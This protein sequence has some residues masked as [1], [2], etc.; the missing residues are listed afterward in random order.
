MWKLKAWEKMPEYMQTEEVRRYYNILKRKKISLCFKRIFDI[1]MSA[2]LLIILS[3]VLLVLSVWIKLDSKGPIFFRQVRITQYGEMF[4]IFKFRTMVNDAER[5]G[6]QV[7]VS[8]DSR[9][10]KVGKLIRKTRL[11]ELPQLLNVLMG[12]MSFVGTRPEVQ[13]YVAQY[14]PKMYAT[15][16]LPAGITSDASIKFKDEDELL[17]DAE[18]VD[19]VYV[20]KVL[21]EKM[22]YNLEMIEKF[23]CLQDLKVMLNTVRAVVERK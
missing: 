19:M 11:D 2:L 4:R 17:K 6:S 1:L 21:P 20:Q 22:K 9:I 3:P 23:S 13:K 12:Q 5:L 7:T 15:L 16:L 10:T 8:N 14:C 18:D